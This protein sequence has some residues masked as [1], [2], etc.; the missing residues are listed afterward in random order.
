MIG[1]GL[2][3]SRCRQHLCHIIAQKQEDFSNDY[4]GS[5]LDSSQGRFVVDH[6]AKRQL[7][8]SELQHALAVEQGAPELDKENI[9]QVEDMVS[10]CA[11]LV[12]VDEKSNFIRLVH[13]MRQDY[14]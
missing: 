9:P 7:T 13:Y 3:A 5:G 11:G 6:R 2:R 14:F 10:V 12:M 1:S 4:P 8:I